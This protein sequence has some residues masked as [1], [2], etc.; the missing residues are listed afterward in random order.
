VELQPTV[1]P[2]LHVPED[3]FQILQEPDASNQLQL[4]RAVSNMLVQT[5][6]VLHAHQILE[7]TP[8]ITDVT[9]FQLVTVPDNTT[10]TPATAIN[11]KP[12]HQDQVTSLEPI[13]PDVIESDFSV[14][15]FQDSTKDPGLANHVTQIT[16]STI[17]SL[18]T[19]NKD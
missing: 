11:V 5:T 19:N 10:V 2:V 1:S 12:A 7:R 17:S 8:P 9:Q 3:W 13:E 15:A 4:V 6:N 14:T 18:T 16:M